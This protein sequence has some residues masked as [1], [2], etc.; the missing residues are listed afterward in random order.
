MAVKIVNFFGP[1]YDPNTLETFKEVEMTS[2]ENFLICK[3]AVDM[4]TIYHALH[5][6]KYLFYKSA[7]EEV[8][9]R[10][11]QD[12]D[13][14]DKDLLE[15]CCSNRIWIQQH[16]RNLKDL[17]AKCSIVISVV[18]QYEDDAPKNEENQQSSAQAAVISETSNQ[19]A[20]DSI[21]TSTNENVTQENQQGITQSQLDSLQKQLLE[22]QGFLEQQAPGQQQ[23]EQASTIMQL[24]EHGNMLP[25]DPNSTAVS[26]ATVMLGAGDLEGLPAGTTLGSGQAIGYIQLED[27]SYVQAVYDT[28]TVNLLQQQ[29]LDAN[30][31]QQQ[32]EVDQGEQHIVAELTAEQQNFLAELPPDQQQQYL[33]QIL[34]EQQQQHQQLLEQ[35]G[36]LAEQ[37]APKQEGT[38]ETPQ[39]NDTPQQENSVKHN[40]E[41]T[42][43][44]SQ[45]EGTEQQQSSA[46]QDDQAI[47]DP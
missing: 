34:L 9:Y 43:Q 32:G 3:A 15:E 47:E 33:E 11:I 12:K 38:S 31:Q 1:T 24:D 21:V 8:N 16:L 13:K 28:S 6:Y 22:Q 40:E 29:Q 5:H 30:Q 45:P 35:Q 20:S 2:A 39:T 23:E 37:D 46:I 25:V 26:G 42:Q 10:R 41:P 44:L 18:T 4:M 27:G 14:G 36:L 7:A 19:Q 17:L